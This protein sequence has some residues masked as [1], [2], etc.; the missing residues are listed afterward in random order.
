MARFGRQRAAATNAER[1]QVH[2]DRGGLLLQ[3]GGGCA[4]AVVPSCRCGEERG[5][6][7]LLLRI[8]VPDPLQTAS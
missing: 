7:N 5:R 4:H 8:S 1:A 6:N 3:M 2:S